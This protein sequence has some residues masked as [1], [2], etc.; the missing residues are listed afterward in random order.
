MAKIIVCK[1][2]SSKKEMTQKVVKV[3]KYLMQQNS[4]FSLTASPAMTLF[5]QH[6]LYVSSCGLSSDHLCLLQSWLQ[7]LS[8]LFLNRKL[9][10]GRKVVWTTNLQ[11]HSF[12]SPLTLTY[13]EAC[14]RTFE[15]LQTSDGEL[16]RRS[17]TWGRH[18]CSLLVHKVTE[19]D[20]GRDNWH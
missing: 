19:T 20:L 10:R 7:W 8:S 4:E 17:W 18:T 15:E 5:L 1:F 3:V 6:W 16:K 9:F 12:P 14:L 13:R 2:S 11:G